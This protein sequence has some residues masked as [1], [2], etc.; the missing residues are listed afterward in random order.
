MIGMNSMVVRLRNLFCADL[1]CFDAICIR[2]LH[3]DEANIS[4]IYADILLTLSD[5]LFFP[6]M[7]CGMVLACHDSWI[8]NNISELFAGKV[9]FISS[10]TFCFGKNMQLRILV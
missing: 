7:N 1:W 5:F 10:S 8:N 2:P 6:F 3:T 4:K 9:T